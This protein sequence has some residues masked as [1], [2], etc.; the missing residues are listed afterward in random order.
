MHC[1]ENKELMDIDL[2]V[3]TIWLP[4]LTP[5]NLSLK[6]DL[7]NDTNIT[8]QANL[9]GHRRHQSS[10]EEQEHHQC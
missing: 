8:I 6:R 1:T 7:L 2:C 4:K 10:H 3:S 5:G 9:N